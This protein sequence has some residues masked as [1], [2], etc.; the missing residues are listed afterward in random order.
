MINIVHS[1]EKKVKYRER[2]KPWITTGIKKSIRIKDKLYKKFIKHRSKKN[3]NKYKEFNN[4]L[5][6]IKRVSER[7]YYSDNLNKHKNNVKETWK[8]L[9]EAIKR[10]RINSEIPEY[11][12]DSEGNI[13]KDQHCISNG[14]NN[15]L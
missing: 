2:D 8:V 15:F 13:I 3:E 12:M 4:K 9:N 7:I 10:K 6:N 1:R 11:F 5:T 14:F